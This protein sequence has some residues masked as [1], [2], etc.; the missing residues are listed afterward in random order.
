MANV[1]FELNYSGV[2]ELLKGAEM[3]NICSQ[4]A[5]KVLNQCDGD[6]TAE[7]VVKGTRVVS[8]VRTDSAHAYYSNRKHKTLQKALGAIKYD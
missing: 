8:T 7:T 4:L 6:Y 5:D 3:Q 2:S 1:K